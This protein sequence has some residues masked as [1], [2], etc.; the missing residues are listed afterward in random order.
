VK[1]GGKILLSLSDDRYI[2]RWKPEEQAN[3][4]VLESKKLFDSKNFPGYEHK[5]TQKDKS[6]GSMEDGKGVTLIFKK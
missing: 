6:A 5:M 3:G 4:F 1:K 2:R